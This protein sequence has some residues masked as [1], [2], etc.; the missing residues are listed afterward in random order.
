[1]MVIRLNVHDG[2]PLY[3]ARYR[4]SSVGG[5]KLSE[6]IMEKWVL[7]RECMFVLRS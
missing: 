5:A 2:R 7:K 3:R 1:M 6:F 4:P